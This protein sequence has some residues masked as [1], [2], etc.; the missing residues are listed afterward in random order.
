MMIDKNVKIEKKVFWISFV[1]TIIFS[2]IGIIAYFITGSQAVLLDGL[3][4]LTSVVLSGITIWVIKI[5]NSKPNK[6]YP[7]GL[8]Q[9][10]PMLEMFKGLIMGGFL[11]IALVE[12]IQK[13]FTGGSEPAG[14][15]VVIYAFITVVG[16]MCVVL[17]MWYV[18][19]G[20]KN[21]SLVK[22]EIV[23]WSQD[24][25]ISAV[26]GVVFAITAWVK[27]P[28]VA[29]ISPYLDS[30]LVII[31]VLLFIPT[32]FAS[33]KNSGKQLLLG[34]PDELVRNDIKSIINQSCIDFNIGLK[35]LYIIFAGGVLY[36]D[37]EVELKESEDIN[38]GI[39]NSIRSTLSN[40]VKDKHDNSEVFV[41]FYQTEN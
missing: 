9:A 7:F 21:S 32:V 12:N 37:I 27:T 40:E 6:D 35:N 5:S 3:F 20:I 18:S 1:G 25:L 16:S 17:F 30:I 11:T 36:I 33:V 24:T 22:L 2:L 14:K 34:S 31:I 4:T 26:I 28:F 10:R 29:K 8:V 39:I 15:F 13:L 38:W 23:Q 19:R 41:G